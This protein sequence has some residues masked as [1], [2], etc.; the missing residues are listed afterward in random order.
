MQQGNSY[1]PATG[2]FQIGTLIPGQIVRLQIIADVASDFTGTCGLISD[3]IASDQFDPD[4]T[5]NNLE[6]NSGEDDDDFTG[7]SATGTTNGN[8]G[9]IE[10]NG[11]MATPLAQRRFAREMDARFRKGQGLRKALPLHKQG[12]EVSLANLIPETVELE[13]NAQRIRSSVD[14]PTDLEPITNAERV[15][16]VEYF[17]DD[18]AQQHWGA[19]FA[20]GTDGE[21]YDHSK[22]TCDR[23][24]GATL[25][26]IRQINVDGAPFLM[27]VLE[28]AD[29][30]VDYSVSFAAYYN[31]ADFTVDSRYT[32]DEYAIAKGTQMFNFQ[33]WSIT[34][35]ITK[36]IVRDMLGEMQERGAVAYANAPV[37]PTTYVRTG[38]YDR[39]TFKL[40]LADY[41]DVEQVRIYGTVADTEGTLKSE[42]QGLRADRHASGPCQGRDVCHRGQHGLGLRRHAV[43]R[44]RHQHRQD[45]LLGRSLGCQ[46]RRRQR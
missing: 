20:A 31:G 14:S 1:D 44:Q 16:A 41:Q 21:A 24:A 34:P 32:P 11:D 18:A 26:S 36:E 22:T 13:N 15:F 8:D 10:S 28:H 3:V 17:T 7:V 9:G 40:Q 29:G 27:S 2:R 38:R 5:P 23:L 12:A 43:Y 46:R 39:G 33:V 42:P 4:S 6:F 37:T 35:D 30:K 25:T 45:L 19:V